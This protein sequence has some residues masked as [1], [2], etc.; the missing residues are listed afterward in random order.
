MNSH[1]TPQRYVFKIHSSRLKRAKWNLT[2]TVSQARESKELI[3]LSES[4]LI[5][6]IDEL[7]G[8]KA[9]K[10]HI[11]EIKFQISRLKTEKNLAVSRPK[12]KKLYAELDGCL[13][14]KDYVCVVIDSN[15]DYYKIYKNGFR[16]NNITYRRLL[17]TT[18]GK[19]KCLRH[20][21]SPSPSLMRGIRG[22]FLCRF[23][24]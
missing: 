12:I 11:S 21:N 16:I 14:Q 18:G 22:F 7:N 3:A 1:T 9:P 5:R 17:G 10:T 6:F 13:F 19:K 4:Q 15:S 24:A 23:P 20:F 2:L 8:I